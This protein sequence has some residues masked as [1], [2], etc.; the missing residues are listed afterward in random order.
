MVYLVEKILHFLQE[1][2]IDITVAVVKKLVGYY[3]MIIILE[4]TRI[5]INIERIIGNTYCHNPFAFKN[6]ITLSTDYL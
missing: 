5:F 6:Q 4:R 3:L 2:F 1:F